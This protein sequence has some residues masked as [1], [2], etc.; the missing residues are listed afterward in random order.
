MATLSELLSRF[1]EDSHIRGH[2]FEHICK[3]Y[4]END[5]K[6]RLEL[7]RV[8]LWKDWLGKWGPDCGIDLI[9]KG[10][11]GKVWAIQA[12][13]YNE[14]YPIKKTDI[15][16]FLSE[17]SRPEISFR[18]LISTTNLMG[19]T[20]QKTIDGQEKKVGLVLLS[21]LE[22]SE[23]EWPDSPDELFAKPAKPKTPLP[24]QVKA[25]DEVT[26]GFSENERGQ[27]IMACGTGKTLASLWI[28]EKLN[29]QR[30]LILLPSLSLL[31]QT[32]REWVINTSRDFHYLPVCSDD[33]V[34]GE[35]RFTS[36]TSELGLPVT[37][38]PAEVA[39]FLRKQNNLIVFSTYQ[40]SPVI[41]KAFAEH[42]IPGFD[43][44]IVD[45]AHRCAGPASGIFSTIMDENRINAK[46][47]L[48]MTATPRY[49]TDKAHKEAKELEYEI[50]SM[51]D[52]EKFG[53][54]FHRLNFSE[55]IR[56]EL[57]SDYQVVIIGVDNSTYRQYAEYEAIVTTNGKDLTDAKTLASQIALLKAMRIYDSKRVISFHGRIKRAKKFSEKITDVMKWMP[58][59]L[60]P[61]GEIWP[62]HVSGEMSSGQRTMHLDRLRYLE[63]GERG[64]LSNARCLGEGVD[65]PT[66]DGVAFID[67]RHSQIDI[68][69]AVGRAI[70]KAP[71][72]K[73]GIIVLPVF[74]SDSQN[75]KAALESSAFKPIWDVLKA[76]R[77]HDDVLA[78]E[79]DSL[80][81]Q[82]DPNDN[83][84]TSVPDKLILDLPITV[85]KSFAED[86]KVRLVKKASSS[87]GG[88]YGLLEQFVE[89]NG[90][91]NI[92]YNLVTK[93]G[94][95]LG[96][97]VKNQHVAFIRGTLSKERQKALESLDG[98]V[99]DTKIIAFLE[100][101]PSLLSRVKKYITDKNHSDIPAG[102]YDDDG[103]PLRLWV[104]KVRQAYQS[105]KLSKEDTIILENISGWSWLT[106]EIETS[107]ERVKTS[108]EK[109]LYYAEWLDSYKH[110]IEFVKNEGHAQVP[111]KYVT[112]N[113]FHLG[114][115]VSR[116]RS[117]YKVGVLA[118]E[119]QEALEQIPEW[120]WTKSVTSWKIINKASKNNSWLDD[121]KCLVRFINLEGH[122]QVPMKY[123]TKNGF[124][125]GTW[126]SRQRNFYKREILPQEHLK[127]L[128]Q[129]PGWSW[130]AI[131]IGWVNNYKCLQ[132][133]VE[134]EGHAQVPRKFVTS[135]GVKLG[136]WVATQ[137]YNYKKGVLLKVRQLALEKIDGWEWARSKAAWEK[138]LEHL[139]QYVRQNGSA[140]VRNNYANEKG[141]KL[142]AWASYQRGEYKKGNLFE[143]EQNV[144]NDL[145]DWSWKA[146]IRLDVLSW[147]DAYEL[148][149][150]FH[151][152]EGHARVH[153]YYTTAGG[154]AL[155]GWVRRQRVVYKKG[156]LSE[157]KRQLLEKIPGWVWDARSDR[158]P[159]GY[160]YLCDYAKSNG[161]SRIPS[162]YKTDDGY[163]L[164]NWVVTQRGWKKKGLLTTERQKK[165]ESIP[166]WVTKR[167][168]DRVLSAICGERPFFII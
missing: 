143:Y 94:F 62:S 9:A 102:Y 168:Y 55:A 107:V 90:H 42:S 114:T 138:G 7:K 88:W 5:P 134:L 8:W 56:K 162:G 74:I 29:C 123:V 96:K 32:L 36:H 116:Q 48:F 66:L 163:S 77:A 25:I 65:V 154:Y 153:M 97:W 49:F 99:W 27:L 164:G 91:A 100:L 24:H 131:S 161:T 98:W 45:E 165:L 39:A 109:I 130:K 34:R 125:L 31:A 18:L 81:R 124:R 38:N 19:K 93:E 111:M 28:A 50:A 118:Q 152:K 167:M 80:R 30:T 89:M 136:S 122:A 155:G 64:L 156:E 85:G 23:I 137:K 22:K 40:S 52:D 3:W 60:R 37:T 115:W 92:P 140:Y 15:D 119:Y 61:K 33:T 144:L 150:K 145:P 103:F 6:Y 10:Y 101:P 128:E 53:P 46:R 73:T 71:D 78:A 120:S 13:A 139:L 1:N 2:Q 112:E 68:V 113:G 14:Q 106:R 135:D 59:E 35:D 76:L 86:F 11:D 12:K 126:V 67:P 147:N 132:R 70:R 43:L 58:E 159:K 129:T 75:I 142:G 79:L 21:D 141:F 44:A 51:D 4:L 110:L 84:K 160:K 95:K 133:F 69:Q 57:L 121:Y 20:A 83:S 82:L 149:I 157:N 16:T 127:T 47:R 166:G 108:G 104:I 158:W 148:L 87:W 105:K 54:C 41:A 117:T 63:D 146:Q 72:K 26:R 17:S 151:E